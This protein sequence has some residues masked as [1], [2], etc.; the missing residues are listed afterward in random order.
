LSK[1]KQKDDLHRAG[2]GDASERLAALEEKIKLMQLHIDKIEEKLTINPFTRD[3]FRPK[4]SLDV[5]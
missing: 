3:N 5:I 1:M 4:Q 2:F